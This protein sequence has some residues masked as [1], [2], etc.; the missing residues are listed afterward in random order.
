MRALDGFRL[1]GARPW[2]DKAASEL[3]A[4]GAATG[5]PAS[6]SSFTPQQLE[7]A[8]LAA[9]GLTNKQIGERLFLSHR[10]VATHLYQLYPKLGISSRAALSDALAELASAEP[11]K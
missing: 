5:R 11:V 1:L 4:A 10:T 9:R 3:R 8:Q 2:M 7:I 6:G